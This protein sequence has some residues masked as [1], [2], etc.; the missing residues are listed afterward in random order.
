MAGHPCGSAAP[1]FPELAEGAPCL[2][3]QVVNG[4]AK[5]QRKA[6]ELEKPQIPPRRWQGDVALSEE[7]S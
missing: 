3:V 6:S 4:D 7:C 1:L 2:L 5:Q